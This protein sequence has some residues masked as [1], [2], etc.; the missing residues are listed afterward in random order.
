MSIWDKWKQKLQ[1]AISNVKNTVSTAVN[2]TK[3]KVQSWIDSAKSKTSTATTQPTAQTQVVD[4]NNAATATDMKNIAKTEDSAKTTSATVQPTTQPTETTTQPEATTT[5][6]NVAPV[7]IKQTVTPTDENAGTPAPLVTPA[8]EEIKS[9]TDVSATDTT[10]QNTTTEN[11]TENTT[12]NTTTENATQNATTD[13]SSNTEDK[14]LKWY[15]EKFGRDYADDTFTKTDEMTDQEYETGNN[16]YQYYLQNKNLKNQYDSAVADVDTSKA[17][18]RQEASILRDKMAKYLD[19]QN[20]NNGLN[21]LGVSESV[22]LQ[23]DSQYATN[24][25]NI[26]ANANSEKTSLLNN[27]I[28]AKNSNDI[29]SAQNEQSILSKYQQYAREDEQT[30]YERQKYEEEQAYQREQDEYNKNLYQQEKEEAEQQTDKDNAYVVAQATLEELI[31]SG[32]YEKARQYLEENKDVF[33]ENVYNTYTSQ[34]GT[35]EIT[36]TT[37]TSTDSVNTFLAGSYGSVSDTYAKYKE[38]MADLDENYSKGLISETDYNDLKDQMNST[39]S[40]TCN[41]G[42]SIQGLGSGRE[43]DDIDITIGSSSRKGNGATEFDLL[44]G[45]AVTDN[46]IKK[47]LNKLATGSENSTPAAEGGWAWLHGDKANSNET[48]GKLVVF[49]NQ[50]FLYTQ[51][52]WVTV[53]G[54]HSEV[55]DAINAFLG[56]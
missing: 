12:Q 51:K 14:F 48:A 10:N 15:K 52:G 24:L 29:A 34:I 5:K 50:M 21:N 45:S 55:Q 19:L 49:M 25:G 20:K 38:I 37:Q 53:K 44:C 54:D 33:G 2:N 39:T 46:D 8:K 30:A 36:T 4:S 26:E 41:G 3:S 13:T 18:Q 28:N 42:W 7:E 43:N 1:T 23:A 22:G 11:T 31:A 16:L 27:Y 32:S 6:P 56:K 47:Q 9:N 35:S 17:Q 40:N